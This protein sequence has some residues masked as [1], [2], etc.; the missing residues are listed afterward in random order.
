M[1]HVFDVAVI[2]GGINGCGCAADASLRGLSV[3]LLEEDDIASKTSSR[4]T[5]L[6]HGGLRYLEQYEFSLV[7]K[8]LKERQTLLQLA[9]HLVHPQAFILPY[10]EHMRP[11]W[12]LRLGLFFYDYLSSKNRLPKCKNIY[13]ND[14]NHYFTPLKDILHRGFLFYDAATDDAR[15]TIM[16]ALQAKNHGASIRLHSRVIKTE[17]RDQLWKITVQPKKSAAYTLWA[18]TLINATGPWVEATAKLTHLPLDHQI[19]LVQGS[20][21]LVPALYQG[22]YAYLL[23]NSDQ[24]VV[25]VIPFNGYSLIGTTEVACSDPSEPIKISQEEIDYLTNLVNSYFKSSLSSKD[26]IH[27]WSGLRPLLAANKTD[28]KLLS[29]DYHY[30]VNKNPAPLVTIYGGKITTYRQLAEEV[31]DQLTC[32]FPELK[33][34]LTQYT[35]LPGACFGQLNFAEYVQYA[36][37]KYHWLERSLLQRYLYTYGSNTELFLA[38]CTSTASMGKKYD[39]SLYQVELDYLIKEEWACESKD[40]LER[41]TKLGFSMDEQAKQEVANYLKFYHQ[42]QQCLV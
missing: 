14:K 16:N 9:P 13:R 24:R 23:Q 40:V 7:K 22:D 17:T 32:V 10:Q 25:F 18:K 38:H 5:K 26:I 37:K 19:I 2:G 28:L 31:I 12:L 20:H 41:R 3:V 21:I 36:H 8:A 35:P 1:E 6:I 11:A 15:L 30:E 39:A 29:R 33:K 42:S 27:S 4:S 34:S